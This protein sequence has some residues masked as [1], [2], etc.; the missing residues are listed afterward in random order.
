MFTL[1]IDTLLKTKRG[2]FGVSANAK[3][4]DRRNIGLPSKMKKI[5]R[6]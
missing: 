6:N 2:V 5:L 3:L 1:V 4:Q